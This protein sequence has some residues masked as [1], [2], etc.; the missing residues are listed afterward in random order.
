MWPA[1]WMMPSRIYIRWMA[2]SGEID[3]VEI[4]GD[5]MQE[6]LSTVHYGADPANHK[7]QGGTLSVK[8][9]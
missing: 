1:I 9:I 5:N 4:R 8:S 3:L 7:Y 2:C 6:I